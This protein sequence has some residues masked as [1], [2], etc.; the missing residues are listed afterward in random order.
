L[1]TIRV[2]TAAPRSDVSLAGDPGDHGWYRSSVHVALSAVDATSGVASIS[3]RVDA[4]TWARYDGPFTVGSGVHTILYSAKDVAGLEELA[5]SVIVRVDTAPPMLSGVRRSG[6]V[7]T[8]R[9][10]VSWSAADDGSGIDHFE[11]SVDG[12]AW[13]RLGGTPMAELSLADG[14]HSITVRAVDVAGNTAEAS[15]S[16]IVDTNA[17]SLGGPLG[18]LP[19][20]GLIAGIAVLVS[21][22]EWLRRRRRA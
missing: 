5:Q 19:T 22:L 10:D 1:E 16:V 15:A 11:I 4:G 13:T 18:A 8:G 6:T 7:S 17:F 20:L 12:G 14:S 21:V 3:Y 2:D 9:V